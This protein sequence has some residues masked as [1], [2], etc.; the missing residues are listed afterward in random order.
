MLSF[1]LVIWFQKIITNLTEYSYKC[2][3][4]I[5]HPV[6]GIKRVSIGHQGEDSDEHSHHAPDGQPD[7][8]A[9][10]L[11]VVLIRLGIP[12]V[13]SFV[14]YFSSE[15]WKWIRSLHLSYVRT[16]CRAISNVNP[17]PEKTT[18]E[19]PFPIPAVPDSGKNHRN[20]TKTFPI[21]CFLYCFTIH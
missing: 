13:A 3:K 12:A 11:R 6:A 17:S 15:L 4:W 18:T 1:S 9:E 5:R 2:C 16:H 19:F 10:S 14:Y 8:Q 7:A 21:P 20:F